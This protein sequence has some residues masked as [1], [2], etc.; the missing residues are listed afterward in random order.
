VGEVAVL[1]QMDHLAL[2]NKGGFERRMAAEPLGP[3]DLDQLAS[4]GI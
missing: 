1:G 3:E 4:L 2:W